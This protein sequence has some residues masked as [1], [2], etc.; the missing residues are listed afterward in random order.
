MKLVYYCYDDPKEF[1][2]VM[3]QVK[4]LG[5]IVSETCPE[6][7]NDEFICLKHNGLTYRFDRY[8]PELIALVEYII[9]LDPCRDNPGITYSG[10]LHIYTIDDRFRDKKYYR[11]KKYRKFEIVEVLYEAICDDLYY[12]RYVKP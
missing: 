6:N 9:L 12:G 10:P 2:R 7:K 8:N 5:Q 4:H 1:T 3:E 11:I